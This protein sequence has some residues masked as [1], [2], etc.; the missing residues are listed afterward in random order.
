MALPAAAAGLAVMAIARQMR[1]LLVRLDMTRRSYLNVIT[2]LLSKRFTCAWVMSRFTLK[3][4]DV[5]S[6]CFEASR[7]KR[8]NEINIIY[9]NI[10]P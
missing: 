1:W 5:F 4:T 3:R 6:A 9:L 7:T 8:Y 10:L 2:N